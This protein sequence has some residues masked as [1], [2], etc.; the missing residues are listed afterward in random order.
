[1]T[2]ATQFDGPYWFDLGDVAV[3]PL[4]EDDR[5][6]IHPDEFFPAYALD[7]GAWCAQ[8]PWL[9]PAS[10]RMVLVIQSFV[11]CDE[12]DVVLVDAC[13]GA[14]KSRRRDQFDGLGATWLDR[15]HDTGIEPEDVSSVVFTHLHTDH[16]GGTTARTGARW[17]PVFPSVPHYVVEEEF[18]YW[19]GAEGGAAMMRTGDYMS[20]SVH[21]LDAR[22]LLE[23]IAPD[24]VLN[25]HVRVVPAA[26]HTPG[27]ICLR[28]QGSAATAILAGD[29]MHHGLQILDPELSTRYCVEPHVASR[30]RR[31][32]LAQA[33]EDGAVVIPTHFPMPSAGR[34][35]TGP[36]GYSFE[37]ASDLVRPGQFRVDEWRAAVRE[38]SA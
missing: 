27:N 5:L 11:V 13:V 18:R 36:S 16:V 37:F 14:G 6:L 15:F 33:A 31:S 10:G 29:T 4:V 32:L 17:E 38:R 34:I 19:S 8:E 3:I 30:V 7:P 22:G 35:G 2:R 26:G 24:A 20:D 23:F 28:V 9:D 1:M 25:Q 12:Q 21:P